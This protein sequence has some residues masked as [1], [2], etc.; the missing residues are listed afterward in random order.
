MVINDDVCFTYQRYAAA[1][2]YARWIGQLEAI[3]KQ[4]QE[5][6]S[7]TDQLDATGH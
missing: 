7:D 6:Y 2:V 1:C 3:A 4:Q 5:V